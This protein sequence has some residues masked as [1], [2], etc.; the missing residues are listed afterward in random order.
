MSKSLPSNTCEGPGH[1][2]ILLYYTN[3][4]TAAT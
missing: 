3:F 1:L 2:C 4:L